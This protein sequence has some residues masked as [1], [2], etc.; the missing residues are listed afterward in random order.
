MRQTIT[1][2]RETKR[3]RF[4]LFA[5]EEFLFSV[6]GE[7]LLKYDLQEGSSLSEGELSS[8][9]ESSDTRK[10]KD[11]ALRFLARRA[12]G[13][14]ELYQKL[15][16]TQD[17]YS[18][19]AALAAMV[20]LGLMDDGQFAAQRGEMLAQKG[21]SSFEIRHDLLSLG[22]DAETVQDTLDALGLDD[23]NTALALLQKRY[24][25]KLL[26]GKKQAVIAALARRGFSQRD[27]F[28]ALDTVLTEQE[29]E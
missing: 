1:G 20:E 5:G 13:Q 23:E 11:Q 29:C 17:E 14:Q 2:I 22:V 4:A 19:A 21:K 10:A 7:T 15:C 18:A 3:G 25:E 26:A 16:R 8:L 27:I 12:H 24:R 9:K 6:D 28:N